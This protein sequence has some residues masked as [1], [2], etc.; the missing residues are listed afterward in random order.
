[1]AKRKHVVVTGGGRGIGAATAR[2][3]KEMGYRVTLMARTRHEIE[4][5]ADELS[6]EVKTYAVRVD[7]GDPAS[8]EAAFVAAGPVDVLVNNAGTV[9][10][11][12][13]TRT[14]VRVWEEHLKVNLTGAFLCALKVLPG[15]IS[16][17]RGR[18]INVAS[19]CGFKGY[20]YLTAY[21]A[22]KAGLVGFT[23]ALAVEVGGKGVTVNAV[24]PGIVDSPMMAAN[25]ELVSEKTD[26]TPE[27]LMELFKAASPQN[28]VISPEEIAE[29]IAFFATDG[30]RGINGHAMVVDGGELVS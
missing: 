28:R 21:S 11:S 29:A 14:D 23:K 12:P 17:E 19:I 25:I 24:C 9:R 10:S 3:F 20:P 7:V 16:R 15:M 5:L 1:M 4:A 27:S 2:K 6:D 8:V 18:I 26:R 13:V 22:S 30:A